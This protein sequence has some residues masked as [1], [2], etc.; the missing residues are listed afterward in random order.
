MFGL[1]E[2]NDK[3][4]FNIDEEI[5]SG[6]TLFCFWFYDLV[7]SCCREKVLEEKSPLQGVAGYFIL[8]CRCRFGAAN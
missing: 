7:K 8:A 6:K 4:K 2:S 5:I 1:T 3:A